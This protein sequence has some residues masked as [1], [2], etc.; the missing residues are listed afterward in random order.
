[1]IN[2]TL[3]IDDKTK[4]ITLLKTDGL[5]KVEVDSARLYLDVKFHLAT[6]NFIRREDNSHRIYDV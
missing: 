5:M 1:M 3:R 6:I 2:Y 4:N